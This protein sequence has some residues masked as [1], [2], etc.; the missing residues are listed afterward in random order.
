MLAAYVD[1]IFV[2]KAIKP[3]QSVINKAKMLVFSCRFQHTINQQ[4]TG[5]FTFEVFF[6][7]KYKQI[8]TET[9]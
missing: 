1:Y 9:W 3:S 2:T 5:V 7:F 6:Y 4:L 8:I